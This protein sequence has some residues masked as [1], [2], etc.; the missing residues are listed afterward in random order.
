MYH[1]T[2][3]WPWDDV[4]G[5]Q[6]T[7]QAIVFGLGSMFNHSTHDQNVGWQRDLDRRVIIYRT[8]RHV[9]QGEE[10]C[11]SY[12]PRLTFIDADLERGERELGEKGEEVLGR[13]ELCE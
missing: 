10:L 13:I 3:N 7:T 4:K 12:G 2:Y 1:Y 6:I 11:I 9:S 8:L 5:R